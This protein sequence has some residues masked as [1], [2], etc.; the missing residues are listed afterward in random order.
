M[1]I[2]RKKG[3]EKGK[4]DEKQQTA[5]NLLNMNIDIAIIEKATGLSKTE[6]LKLNAIK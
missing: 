4:K 1:E 3:I 6:I 5:I 2:R